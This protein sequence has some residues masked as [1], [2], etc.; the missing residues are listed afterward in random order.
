MVLAV[1]NPHA[2]SG[3]M[4][5]GFSLWVGKIPWRRA[6]QPT[7]IFLPGESHGERD[8]AGYKSMRSQSQTWLKR[9]SIHAEDSNCP[10]P[11]NE[12]N[13]NIEGRGQH[14][15][16][17]QGKMLKGLRHYLKCF[18][19]LCFENN[20]L[21]WPKRSAR[22]CFTSHKRKSFLCCGLLAALLLIASTY[23]KAGNVVLGLR[24]DSEAFTI[25]FSRE[26]GPLFESCK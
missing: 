5:C 11:L 23:L 20:S 15:S 9:L 14:W 22:W 18:S 26:K 7:P 4:R 21:I 16:G 19:G 2:N 12:G 17:R 13:W 24:V 8:L 3:N 10:H 1:K 25:L 6:W